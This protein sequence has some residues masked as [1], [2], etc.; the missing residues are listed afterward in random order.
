MVYLW[1]FNNCQGNVC[2]ANNDKRKLLSLY[3][4]KSAA[5]YISGLNAAG[6]IAA[7]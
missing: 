2:I 1:K 5:V 6:I 4:I 3:K 7:S